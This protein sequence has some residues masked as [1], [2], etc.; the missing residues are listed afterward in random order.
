MWLRGFLLLFCWIYVLTLSAQ[1]QFISDNIRHIYEALPK[2]SKVTLIENKEIS[3]SLKGAVYH[4][5][6]IKESNRIGQ[7]GLKVFTDSIKNS[8]LV[9]CHFVERELLKFILDT[10]REHDIRRKE[11]HIYIY[12]A[13][14]FQDFELLNNPDRIND[15]I[16]DISGITILRDSINY[17]FTLSNTKGER[18]ALKFPAINSLIRGMDKKELEDELFYEMTNK[19]RTSEPKLRTLKNCEYKNYKDLLMCSGDVFMINELSSSTYYAESKDSIYL[20]F[21][22]KYPVESLSN[23]F[24]TGKSGNKPVK[25]KIS[26]KNYDNQNNGLSLNVENLLSCFNNEFMIYFGIED[27]CVEHLRG[28]LII[29]NPSLNYLH[30]LDIKTDDIALF[31]SNGKVT[32]TLYAYI[33]CHNVKNLFAKSRE[34]ESNLLQDLL[35]EK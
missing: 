11:D 31:S 21:D 6:I 26:F 13:D 10:D 9:I 32:G 28:M 18:L 35:N 25:I 33:P 27:S 16:K 7:I 1:E 30:L 12:F 29:S 19:I 34:T 2:N 20:V 14:S 23:L 5:Y 17:N 15:V 3:C 8:N 4:L 22:K 24:L